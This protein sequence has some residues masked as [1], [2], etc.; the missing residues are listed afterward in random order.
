MKLII[1]ALTLILFA[2]ASFAH[3][4][5]SGGSR[6]K[7]LRLGESVT[8]T[9][10]STRVA[11]PVVISLWDG[12]RR[13]TTR[14][15]SAYS[16]SQASFEWTIPDTVQPGSLYRFIVASSS[17]PT[18]GHYSE[19]F[20]SIYPAEQRTSAVATPSRDQSL[21]ITPVPAHDVL[22]VQW[23]G[24]EA[25]AL[26]LTT[27]LGT[28]ITSWVCMNGSTQMELNVSTVPS[29]VYQLTLRY[30]NGDFTTR[31]VVIQH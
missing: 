22:R 25:Q 2:A 16:A 17:S 3:V 11:S 19:S 27:M 6:E 30:A 15:Q 10:D 26:L 31:T 21:Q 28:R 9:W 5:P 12:E 14:I 23:G 1:I 8:I 20:V 18:I 4:T 29:G 13:R 24:S 7:P